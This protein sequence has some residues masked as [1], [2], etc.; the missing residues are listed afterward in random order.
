MT[1]GTMTGRAELSA[2]LDSAWDV[3]DEETPATPEM[4]VVEDTPEPEAKAVQPVAEEPIAEA[5]VTDDAPALSQDER[6][7]WHRKDGTIASR[8]EVE[9]FKAGQTPA[10]AVATPEAP[11]ATPETTQATPFRYRAI[12]QTLTLEGATEDKDGNV[13]IP[14][15]QVP[16]LR[17]KLAGGEQ[18]YSESYGGVQKAQELERTIA[19]LRQ[20]RSA[21]EARSEAVLKRLD[22][23]LSQDMDDESALRGLLELRAQMP[24]LLAKAEADYYKQQIGKPQAQAQAHAPETVEA[25]QASGYPDRE[26]IIAAH[27]EYV[28]Q[29]KLLPEF[30]ALT[31]DDWRQLAPRLER[32]APAF[33]RPARADEAKALGVSVGAYIYDTDLLIAEGSDFAQRK[34]AERENAK[35]IEAANKAAAFNKSQTQGTTQTPAARAARPANAPQP[36]PQPTPV[37]RQRE[38][39]KWK[40]DFLNSP[41]GAEDEE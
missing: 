28:E 1:D 25:Q 18:F 13:L 38:H 2:A 7:R 12:G 41:L 9:A 3:A 31:E 5:P 11:A 34:T 29:M 21:S 17:Q 30:R 27:T 15:S 33:L 16:T 19:E 35:R 23:L 4:A 8:D 14:A 20:A 39:A 22:P 37:D 6:G 26:A 40:R 32:M 36:K 10:S 24:V